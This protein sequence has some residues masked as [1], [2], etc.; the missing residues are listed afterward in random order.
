MNHALTN[1]VF[2]EGTKD[3]N[4]KFSTLTYSSV[5]SYFTLCKERNDQST[6]Y[7]FI[8]AGFGDD[9]SFEI[10]IT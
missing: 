3:S 6:T 5:L 7:S 4:Y 9:I 8:P 1:E 10:T 2:I